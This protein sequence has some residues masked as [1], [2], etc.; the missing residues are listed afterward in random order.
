MG[1]MGIW[2]WVIILAIVLILFGKGK[3]SGLLGDLGKGVRSFKNGIADEPQND[4]PT[5]TSKAE[6]QPHA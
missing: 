4:E 2:Q 5:D 1:A 6:G 3:I